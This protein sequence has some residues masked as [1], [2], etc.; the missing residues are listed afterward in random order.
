MNM[1]TQAD[2]IQN[3]N[4]RARHCLP[5]VWTLFSAFA[6][7]LFLL[8]PSQAHRGPIDEIDMCRIRVG[9]ERIHLTAYT[10][11]F[12][13][14]QGFCQYIPYVG[15]TDL[16]FDY[17]GQKLRDVSIEFEVTKEPEGTRIYYHDPEKI[18]KGTLD[19]SID[20][21]KHGAGDYLVHITIVSGGE[22]LDS[23]LTLFVGTAEEKTPWSLYI[24]GV[25]IV[26]LIV[27]FT[28]LTRANKGGA[29]K[30]A[31]EETPEE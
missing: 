24:F 18:K 27:L 3:N 1:K 20:F 4:K 22:K 17:E 21:E 23:H 13:Q 15:Q 19:A 8:T 29:A 16:V 26:A 2:N 28:I 5:W 30:V 7:N 6:L 14:G 25:V 31:S 10:P 11:K 9:T 12:S